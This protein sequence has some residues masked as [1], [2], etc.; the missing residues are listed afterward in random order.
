MIPVSPRSLKASFDDRRLGVMLRAVELRA[1]PEA[2]VVA[3]V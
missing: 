3:Q 2:H 1:S